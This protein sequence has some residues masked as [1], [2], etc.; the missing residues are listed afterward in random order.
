M[1]T[2][3]AMKSRFKVTGTGKLVRHKQGRRHILN[4]KS[5]KRKRMLANPELVKS[6]H[7]NK[8]KMMM[9]VR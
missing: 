3:K 1:K 2:N 8:Y 4:K 7:L 5:S 9:G 6:T